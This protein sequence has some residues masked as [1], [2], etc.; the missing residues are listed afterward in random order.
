MRAMFDAVGGG[1]GVPQPAPRTRLALV[2]F[3]IVLILAFG[4]GTLIAAALEALS[5]MN[6]R[7]LMG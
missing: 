2:A 3:L 5:D 7:G 6:A 4:F 1:G